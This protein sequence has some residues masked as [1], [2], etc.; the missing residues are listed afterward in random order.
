MIQEN[1]E[2]SGEQGGFEYSGIRVLVDTEGQGGLQG[3]NGRFRS[4]RGD[5]G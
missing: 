5:S 3:L 1:N 4:K 2:D